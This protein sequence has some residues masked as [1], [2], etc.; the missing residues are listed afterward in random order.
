MFLYY[1]F[2][3]YITVVCSLSTMQ[4]RQVNSI[5]KNPIATDEMK[6]IVRYKLYTTHV[7]WLHHSTYRYIYD[8]PFLSL[9]FN[10]KQKKELVEYA[11]IGLLSGIQNFNGGSFYAYTQM[12]VMNSIHKGITELSPIK[13]LPHSYRVRKKW[14][15]ENQE[16]YAK[17]MQSPVS[18]H[19]NDCGHQNSDEYNVSRTLYD[20]REEINELLDIID[21]VSRRVFIMKYNTYDFRAMRSNRAVGELMAMSE[22]RVRKILK[23]VTDTLLVQIGQ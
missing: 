16:V 20:Y 23:L 2:V 12:Y 8:Q 21:P 3:S 1:I 11:K 5:L 7:A 18:Y 4:W 9:T 22:E 6:M 10:A 19:D 17:Y 14:I 13:L 15:A